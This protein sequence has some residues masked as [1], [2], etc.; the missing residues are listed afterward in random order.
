MIDNPYMTATIIGYADETG[1]ES[2]NQT[3]SNK[4]AKNVYDMLVAAGVNS[5]RMTYV[6]GGVDASVGK[7][8]R[9]LA[10]KVIFKIQ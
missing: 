5:S 7:D 1:A 4:R 8:A 9:Q 3:L 2:R 6:G 10:R